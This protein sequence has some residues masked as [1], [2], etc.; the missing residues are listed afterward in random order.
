[1]SCIGVLGVI[2][3]YGK[4]VILICCMGRGISVLAA[5]AVGDGEMDESN[6]NRIGPGDNNSSGQV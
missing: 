1:M 2:V 3:S 6:T 4:L 5:S